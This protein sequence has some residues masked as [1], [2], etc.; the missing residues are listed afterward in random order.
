MAGMG[1]KAEQALAPSWALEIFLHWSSS[2]S[3]KLPNFLCKVLIIR[4]FAV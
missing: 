2:G 3:C 1:H 4:V